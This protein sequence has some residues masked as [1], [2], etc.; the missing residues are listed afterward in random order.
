MHSQVRKLTS[1]KP[2]FTELIWRLDQGLEEN[3]RTREIVKFFFHSSK[4]EP[5][6]RSCSVCSSCFL[7]PS[8]YYN[9]CIYI[10]YSFKI[11]QYHYYW[12]KMFQYNNG[13]IILLYSLK[14]PVKA[15][16]IDYGKSAKQIFLWTTKG[17]KNCRI[18]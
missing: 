17:I 18:F 1:A 6:L 4:F 2:T 11:I 9:N 16:H 14:N 5:I 15:I 8:F 12:S 3:Q 7:V 10:K 13:L